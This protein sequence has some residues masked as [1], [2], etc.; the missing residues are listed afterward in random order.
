MPLSPAGKCR[1]TH[2]TRAHAASSAPAGFGRTC[3]KQR[4]MS[5][6]DTV[7][8]GFA[9]P[10]YTTATPFT[11]NA[12]QYHIALQADAW[13]KFAASLS[14]SHEPDSHNPSLAAFGNE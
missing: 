13:R 11:A 3:R 9:L 12:K 8:S 1:C 10:S 14:K 2:A 5:P 4:V 7:H 6:W